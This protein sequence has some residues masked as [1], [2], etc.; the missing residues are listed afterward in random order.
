[1]V[2][3]VTYEI[4]ALVEAT[5]SS[6][7]QFKNTPHCSSRARVDITLLTTFILV[8]PCFFAMRKGIRRSMVSPD[9]EIER[10]PPYLISSRSVD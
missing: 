1:M 5:E 3:T 8:R 9:W 2:S 10:N 4:K 7:P 6:R